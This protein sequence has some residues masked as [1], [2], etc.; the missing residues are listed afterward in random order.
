[1]VVRYKPS[2]VR[3]FK[4]L[5]QELQE[6]AFAKIALFRDENNHQQLKAHKLTGK[7]AGCYSFSVSYSHRI[8]FEYEGKTDVVFLM[9]GTHDIYRG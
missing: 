8:V 7:L 4:K 2:F 9:I 5:P 1:M 6:E 3:E